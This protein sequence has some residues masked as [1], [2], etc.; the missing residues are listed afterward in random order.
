MPAAKSLRDEIIKASN[1]ADADNDPNRNNIESLDYNPLDDIMDLFNGSESLADLDSLMAYTNGYKLEIEGEILQ[2]EC[3]YNQRLSEVEKPSMELDKLQMQLDEL[4]LE[5]NSTKRLAENTG[6]TINSMTANIKKLDSCKKNLTLS[7]TILKRL[8]MLVTAYDALEKLINNETTIRDYNQIK[9]LLSAVLE[10]MQHFQTYKSIDEINTLNK[11][12][13]SMRNR[14]IDEIFKD[15]EAE[16]NETLNNPTILQ[17][18]DILDI[19]GKAYRDKLTNWYVNVLLKEL[20][21]IFRSSEE[22]G[23]LE[24]LNRRYIFFQRILTNFQQVHSKMFPKDWKMP[25]ALSNRFC[26]VTRKDL[27]EVTAKETRLN[28]PHVDAN[29][30]LTALAQTLDF[31]SYLNQKFKMYSDFGDSTTFNFDRSISDVFEP[32]LNVWIDHQGSIIERKF[33]DYLNPSS[34]YRKS[35]VAEG[36]DNGSD[37]GHRKNSN[38]EEKSEVVTDEGINVLESAADLFRNYRQMLGQLAKLTHGRPLIRLS[39]LFSKYLMEYQRR[40]LQILI[41]DGNKLLS[42]NAQ[43][44]AEVI[45]I[46]CLVLNTADYC[47][48]TTSQLSVKLCSLLEPKELSKEIDFSSLEESFLDMVTHCMTA[49][50]SKI[51]GDL[52]YAWREMANNNWRMMKEV[53]GESRHMTSIKSTLNEDCE[54][55]FDKLNKS[56]YARN[57]I[58]KLAELVVD[59]MTLN[60][61]KLQPITEVMAEQFILDLQT[62][63]GFFL[64]LP[65]KAAYGAKIKGSP[66]FGKF[67]SSKISEVVAL[68]KVLMVPHKPT[69]SYIVNYFGNI[70]DSNFN[71]F[72]K[73]LKL[74]GMLRNDATFE[75]DKFKYMDLFKTQLRSFQE[76]SDDNLDE[77]NSFIERLNVDKM[78]SM[79]SRSK[80]TSPTIVQTPSISPSVGSNISSF[81]NSSRPNFNI[82]RHHLEKNLAKTFSDNKISFGKFFKKGAN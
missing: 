5:F 33:L 51:D 45:D 43:E 27:K 1:A 8:Q 3:D 82:D 56:S 7:M 61:V 37:V 74:K 21:G 75:K 44:Q 14:V 59:D 29:L 68:M 4:L 67:I 18:C 60:I 54:L 42:A 70:K 31:E 64:N 62:L 47:S 10:L 80:Y 28:G 17:A 40:I 41:P 69:D 23:S 49:I 65:L 53:T 77:S 36:G 57:F 13:V 34:M 11:K 66:N 26:E 76:T 9:Q 55:I 39:K 32:Y 79:S 71:N 20:T 72:V 50:Y 6:A 52:Q 24:N 48:T 2:R 78:T 38:S 73:T 58:D 16:F 81:F 46:V 22:A 35:G 19:L 25:I 63:K 30:L 15:F 12:I